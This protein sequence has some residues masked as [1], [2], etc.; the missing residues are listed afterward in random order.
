MRNELSLKCSILAKTETGSMDTG[1]DDPVKLASIAIK[2]LIYARG[3]EPAQGII[4]AQYQA[5]ARDYVSGR[6]QV[7]APGYQRHVVNRSKELEEMRRKAR[8]RVGKSA[9]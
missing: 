5:H 9:L 8:R 2:L 6:M 1:A 4:K 3:L 7:G